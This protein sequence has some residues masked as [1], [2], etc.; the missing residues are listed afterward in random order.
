MKVSV[1]WLKEWVKSRL[2]TQQLAEKLTMAGL[3]VDSVDQVAGAFT[4]IVVAEVLHTAAHPQAD[5]LTLCEVSV[6]SN[7]QPL[8]IVCGASNVRAGLKVALAQM[9]ACLPGGMIIKE[10]RLRGELSQGMLCSSSELGLTDTS[11]GILELDEDAPVGENLRDYL[12]LDD[13]IL[14]IEL[15]PNRADC[16]SILGIARELAA[17]TQSSLKD[18]P[19]Q[20]VSPETDEQKKIILHDPS[21]CPQYCGRV[22]KGINVHAKTPLWMRERLRRSGIRS[23]HPAVDVMNYVMIELGQPM[24]AYDLNLLEGDIHVRFAHA[25]EPL[26]LLDGQDVTLKADELVIADSRKALAIAGIIG[27]HATAV[28]EGTCD[29][30]LES[31]FFNPLNIIGVARRYGLF[32][33]SSQRFERGV[34]FRLQMMAM[35]RAT[36]LLLEIAG[37]TAGPVI[38]EVQEDYLPEITTVTFKPEKVYQLTGLQLPE[39]HMKQI[40]NSLDLSVAVTDSSW[41]VTV[42]SHRFDIRLDVDL[43]EEI[44]RLYGYDNIPREK[45]IGALQSG[46]TN[47]IE[48]LSRTAALFFTARGYHESITYSF[49]DP[50]LQEVLY[51]ELPSLKLLNPISPELSHMRTG[52]W[53]G[54]IA[55]MVYNIHRQQSSI[56]FFETGVIFDITGSEPVEFPVIAGLLA[57]EKSS[58][59]WSETT[60][61]F[62]FYDL[63][64]DL[65]ALFTALGICSI[66]FEAAVHPALHPGKSARILCRGEMAGWCG[67]LHPRIADALG[68]SDEINLFELKLTAILPDRVPRYQQIS[69]FPQIRRDLSLL[70]NDD[71]QVAQI[72][73]LVRDCMQHN[74]LKS[75]NIFDVYQG[76]SIPAG[77]KSLAIAL[78]LQ[79]DNRTL[80]DS[81]IND[82]INAILEKLDG[83]LAITLRD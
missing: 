9:G 61:N 57:G 17:L 80:I 27:G 41:E 11:E 39:S 55:S 65:Q 64:G 25:N 30:F 75:F 77:K 32:T 8:N 52:M 48:A 74:W 50:E 73:Q 47:P 7:S 29:I 20:T 42:P 70:V 21:A 34:D 15:T 14:D 3:E 12:F 1:A 83:E 66:Q 22:I 40:L 19:S 78:I 72:E 38:R 13:E 53:S 26:K 49:V 69:K 23:I 4:G 24:H 63:K 31:A 44:V 18:L 56:K 60:D 45:M 37:G 36:A 10:T 71:I 35:E 76:E 67:V 81:E 2:D 28:Q 43:V 79:D 6:G 16:L 5:K 58:L 68:I 59:S 51:P 62:D 82:V 33:D 54:L 46:L